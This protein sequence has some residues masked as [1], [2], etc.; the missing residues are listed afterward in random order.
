MQLRRLFIVSFLLIVVS[1][2]AQIDRG[3]CHFARNRELA[4]QRPMTQAERDQIDETIARSDTFD[5]QHYQITLDVTDYNGQT[6]KAATTVTY[7]ALMAD[8][9]FI[10]F[11]LRDLVVDS[12]IGP[13]G[14]MTFSYDGDFL[15]CDF[16]TAPNVGEDQQLTV[17]YHGSPGDDP[18]WGGFYFEQ[19]Y[20]YNLGIGLST[21]PPNFGKVWYPCFDSFVERA[22]YTY[23][24][25]S[26]GTFRFHGQGDFLA[27]AQLGGDTVIRSYTLMQQ[28]P[29]HLSAIAVA[30]YSEYN[31]TH[32]GANGDIPVT[33]SAK[34]SAMSAMISKF[35]DLGSAIDACEYWYGPY[36][37][38]RVGYVLTTDG[39]LEIPTNVAYPD[40]MPSQSLGQNRKLFTH[41]LGH[42]W[43]GDWVTPHVHNDMWLK[44]GPAEYS[45]HLLEEWIN[46]R[47]SFVSIVKNNLLDIMTSAHVDDDGFQALSPMPDEHIYGTHTYYKGAAV[48][49]NLRGYL[50]DE[51]FRTGM[52]E[53]Q[54]RL[55]N[56]D[57]TPEQ[58]RDTLEAATGRQLDSFF[59]DWVFSPGYA[60][61]EVRSF[62]SSGSGN[63]WNVDLHI[64]QK[65]Y[66]TSGYH[67]DTP[68]DLTLLAADGTAHEQRITAS[69]ASTNLQVDCPF[70]P[71]MAVLNRH[72][73]LNQ[74]RMDH[75]ITLVPG[76]AF[77]NVLPY[78]EFRLYDE[79]L[80][81]STLVRVDHIW[82]GADVD[83]GFG[84]TEISD[85][86][87]WNVDGLW[88]EGTVLSG[89]MLYFG[90]A[91][92]QFD[93]DLVNGDETG[94]VAVH[95]PNADMPWQV[96]ADQTVNAG[97]LTNGTGTIILN[98]LARGQYA[99]AK[100]VGA[101]GVPEREH[102]AF[103][104]FPVP[105]NEAL[106]IRLQEP[107]A[108]LLFLD[109]VAADGKLVLRRTHGTAG[110]DIA[111]DITE[112]E[113]GSYWLRL[114]T[115]QGEVLG[116]R[117][118]QVVR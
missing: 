87:Y 77:S 81:D 36:S 89:R 114:A 65:L 73:T 107:A 116:A 93:Y 34:P 91:P 37:Y 72:H 110:T 115:A 41:E 79:T 46:G 30:D 75:E 11:D 57:M 38:G 102:G 108:S 25:K 63:D 112:L 3:G 8:Q 53:V 69:G 56:R 31:Y 94:M 49:H 20:I 10:R 80:V 6:I 82:S 76:Q 106:T 62:T 59:Q 61:F 97:S 118:F 55:A 85:R 14:V 16:E 2:S 39:A 111:L 18:V 105:S 17:Y 28:I 23:N 90:G 15:K 67:G 64:G 70:E 68:L 7:R 84:I 45:A 29:T 74:A 24:V 96:Y 54:L 22:S 103:T 104:L 52:R 48:L 95:R 60:V 86:H 27:E 100:M 9:A 78:V 1:A 43:W 50:G 83:L 19:G 40:F 47:A 99:F 92:T 44:E 88:P 109:V 117:S 101:I 26:A 35:T 98:T 5:I 58:F 51:D 21:I 71:V 12:V 42:H 4:R 113:P 66:G 33:L 13:D 32:T